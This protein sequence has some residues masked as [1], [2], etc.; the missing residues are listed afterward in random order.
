MGSSLCFDHDAACA[1]RPNA[2]PPLD[3]LTVREAFG[4]AAIFS[5]SASH[6]DGGERLTGGT[7]WAHGPFVRSKASGAAARTKGR[8][9]PLSE[10]PP[11]GLGPRKLDLR[12]R[13]SEV[14]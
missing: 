6:R 3:S 8:R 11:S 4:A 9:A 1:R 12:R 14:R 7:G 2:V 13:V 10:A 5:A